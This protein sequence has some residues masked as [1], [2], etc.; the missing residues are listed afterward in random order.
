MRCIS[1]TVS[2]ALATGFLS[3]AWA[4]APVRGGRVARIPVIRY[5]ADRADL[6]Y[7]EPHAKEKQALYRRINEERMAAGLAPLE[8]SLRAAKAADLFCRD[9][10]E[11][12]Y[13]GHWDLAGRAPYLRWADAGGV[14]QH[15]QNFASESRSPGPIVGSPKEMLLGSH[16]RMMAEVPPHDGHRRTVLDPDWTHV[17]I[18]VAVVGGEFRMSEEYVRKLMDWVEVPARPLPA[19]SE[20]PFAAKAPAGWNVGVVE[21]RREPVPRAMTPQETAERRTYALPPVIRQIYAMPGNGMVWASGEKGSF[22]VAPDG[23]FRFTVPLDHGPGDYYVVVFASK[24]PFTGKPVT[25]APIARIR[26]E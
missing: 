17:G 19:G 7:E 22:P 1:V 9:S 16:A 18:G 26:A 3:P 15:A 20:A 23:E 5:G 6:P 14:D 8:Y 24:G 2:V 25:P 21:V 10:A 11:K 4:Q 13:T 12:G